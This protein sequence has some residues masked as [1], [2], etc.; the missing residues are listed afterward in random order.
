MVIDVAMDL[1]DPDRSGL[2][3]VARSLARSFIREFRDEFRVTLAGP[4]RT[5]EALGADEWGAHRIV[6]WNAPRYSLA[7]ELQWP[8]VHAATLGACWYFP[9]WD[10][11]WRIRDLPFVATVHDVAH[12]VLPGQLSIK[13]LVA[14]VWMR[15]T[16]ARAARILSVSEH[17]ARELAAFWPEYSAKVSVAPNG[18][19][20]SFFRDAPSLPPALASR[21]S[22]DPMM[23]SIGIRK[24][25]KNLEMGVEILRR[26]P[27][28]RWVVVGE[29]FPD[30]RHVAARAAAAGV[31]ER[32][33]VLD[34]VDDDTLRALFSRA[35]FLLFP[36][37]YEGFGLPLIEALASGTPVIAS[38]ATSI[39]EVLGD[40][41]WLCD[42]DDAEAFAAAARDVLTLGARKAEIAARGRQRA[43]QFSW[44]RSAERLADAL[45]AAA[46]RRG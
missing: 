30:W 29:W 25:R 8:R 12:L 37:R 1:R 35:A 16:L 44:E 36:S 45:R 41:G 42:P 43:R 39:P 14:R 7:A 19:D 34:R 15:R 31:T 13:R 32:L 40:T 2:A 46:G 22:D 9:H 4:R 38:H 20:P 27:D 23:L 10:V 33:V 28:L 21:V 18:V 11:P 17:S 5:L 24:E 6:S 26:I 3:R